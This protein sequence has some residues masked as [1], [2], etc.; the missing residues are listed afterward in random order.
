[1]CIEMANASQYSSSF[2]VILLFSSLLAVSAA[3]LS[4]ESDIL[5]ANKLL[6]W[7]M[8]EAFPAEPSDGL[9]A[10]VCTN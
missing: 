5:V 2:V 10:E 4:Q 9:V 3:P 8:D 1:M 6:E 7:A